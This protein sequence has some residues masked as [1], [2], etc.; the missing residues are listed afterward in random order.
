MLD[1]DRDQL[2]HWYR[3]LAARVAP[4][5]QAGE[6]S[7]VRAFYKWAMTMRL[8]DEDPSAALPRPRVPQGR[9]RPIDTSALFD[10]MACCDDQRVLASMT[11]AAYAGLRAAEVAGAQ[12]TDLRDGSITVVGKGGRVRLVPAHNLVV[13][14]YHAGQPYVVPR[15]DGRP[16]PCAPWLISQIVNRHLHACGLD[17]TMHSLRHWFA[18]YLYRGTLDVRLTQD[19]LGHSSPT[20]TALYADWTHSGPSVALLPTSGVA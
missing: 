19:L 11:L 4:S 9:P 1:A 12:R 5:T 20:T 15:H 17:D 2:E 14:W 10:A 13:G 16:G 7:G 18:T 3:D 8:L 6:L